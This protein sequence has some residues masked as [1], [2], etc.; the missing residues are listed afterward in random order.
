MK[1]DKSAFG[2]LTKSHKKNDQKEKQPISNLFLRKDK[3]D[4]TSSGF[5]YSVLGGNPLNT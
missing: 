4:V 2:A 3:T 5:D 1:K